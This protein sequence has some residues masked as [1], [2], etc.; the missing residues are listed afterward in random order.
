MTAF[1][2]VRF[3]VKPGR[4]DEFLDAHRAGRAKWPGLV[5]GHIV[6]TGEHTFC[7]IGEWADT[8][9]IKGAMAEMIATL[10][11]FRDT[12]EDLG[13]G[14]GVTDAVSGESVVDLLT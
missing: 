12:L 14:H 1:N 10:N 4:E 13:G 8:A 7:L 2:V 11:S 5:A 6:R 9:S 3:R